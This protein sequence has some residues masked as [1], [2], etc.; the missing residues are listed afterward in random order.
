MNKEQFLDELCKKKEMSPD[1]HGG[2]YEL[3]RVCVDAYRTNGRFGTYTYLDLNAIYA[4]ALGTWKLNIEKKKEY[5]EK[6]S[7]SAD[8][9]KRVCLVLDKVWD[10]A[11]HKKYENRE[12][13]VKPTVGMFGT[14]FYSFSDVTDD[15][16]QAFIKMLTEI[17]PLE[18]ENEIFDIVATVL[19]KPIKGIQAASA[20]VILH[21]LKPFVFP[22]LNENSGNGTVYSA[23]G[24]NLIRPK[25]STTYISNCRIIK[26]FRDEHFSFKNYRILDMMAWENSDDETPEE[27]QDME[28]TI[29]DNNTI[30]YGP[31]GTGKTYNTVNYA[32]AIIEGKSLEEVKSENYDVVKERYEQYKD[33]GQIAFTTFHQS[34]GYEEFIEGIKP[35]MDD[36]NFN[37]GYKIESGVFKSFCERASIPSAMNVAPDAL[38]WFVRLADKQYC[39]EDGHLLF[40]RSNDR[41]N[42]AWFIDRFVDKMKIGDFIISYAGKGELIDAI[43]E[44]TGNPEYNEDEGAWDREV[45]WHTLAEPV[46]VKD[47]NNGKYLPNYEIA[48]IKHM[49]VADL[50]KLI[51]GVSDSEAKPCVFVID[52]INRG[53]ISKIFGELITLIENTKRAGESEATNCTLPYSGDEFSVPNNVYILGTMNT[54]DRSISLLDTAL[55]R[56]FSFIEMMPNSDVLRDMGIDTINIDG[57]TLNV[58]NMLDAINERITFLFDREHTIGHAFFTGLHNNQ[59]IE[60]LASIFEKNVI[61]LLQEYFYE[62]YQKIQLVLGDNAKQDDSLK[63]VVNKTIKLKEL[64][65]GNV[66]DIVDE[67]EVKYE[68]N[69]DAFMNIE[70]YKTI[71]RDL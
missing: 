16:A 14:G 15:D 5:I 36:S 11:C 17:E 18:E 21:C 65:M 69:H 10:N 6:S 50:V 48:Q 46:N 44:V 34:Y 35:V 9:Q 68:I 37:L 58:A 28:N 33:A 7:L 41:D 70:A 56:R 49:L 26:A 27:G 8:E 60:K 30:L 67:Q 43:G 59:S 52:E 3:M 1:E 63:F 12:S 20:S 4:M 22:I 19:D 51:P 25:D 24:L 13:D 61:P 47:I 55:R 23:L 31:P 53:N 32:V 54:A 64:F 45:L 38:I 57:T 40:K 2:S 42:D 39:F 29:F 71:A 62:D 66:E